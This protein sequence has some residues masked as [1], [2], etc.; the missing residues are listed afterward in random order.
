MVDRLTSSH[1]AR[2][3]ASASGP[4]GEPPVDLR[5]VSRAL[6]ESR[7]LVAA[8]VVL[9]T[10]IVLVVS[11][12]SPDRYRTGARIADDP[13]ATETGD[14]TTADRRLATSSELV[15]GPTVLAGAARQIPGESASSLAGKVTAS[16]DPAAGILD[17]TATDGDPRRAARIANAVAATFLTE[18]T[19][20]ERREA[21]RARE[22]FA[23]EIAAQQKAGATAET[24]A[25]LRERLSELA[26]AEVT[27]GS[28]LRL[29]Q[30][31]TPPSQ[32]YAP[33]PVRS[34]VIAFFAA[35]FAA[36]LIALARDRLRSPAPDARAL[37]AA[38]EL[39]LIA[40]LPAGRGWGMDRTMIEEAA[41]QACVRT[42]LPPRRQRV[43]LVRGI[44]GDDGSAAVAAALARA[45]TW[46]G[47][48]SVLVR[49]GLPA[50]PAPA[51]DVPVI[52]VGDP[53]E[54]LADLR[55]AGYRYVIV[56]GPPAG[57]AT[58]LR[59]LARNATAVIAVARLGRSSLSG[60]AATRRLIDALS[61]HGLGLVVT[62]SA[63]EASEIASEGFDA[64]EP[65]PTRPRTP[66]QNGT[67]DG[68][69][70]PVTPPAV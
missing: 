60:A 46:A 67:G 25:A 11:L 18:R 15:T 33:K 7:R 62:C 45:L 2:T 59:Q 10:A 41:L 30:P 23:A 34:A 26:V 5:R 12:G 27:A 48:P 16:V 19:R 63:A 39:P 52:A 24:L 13:A 36:V 69:A 32:P 1:S 38:A 57:D 6:R 42:V 17:V 43:V 22:R 14:V 49:V 70:V 55:P 51:P 56:D 64:P 31:A 54:E 53:D 4:G 8:I 40:A 21:A 20:L 58:A 35:L 29:A 66:S 50:G 47:H 65:L 28:G 9:V 37:G 68:S 61:L 3:D 44:D